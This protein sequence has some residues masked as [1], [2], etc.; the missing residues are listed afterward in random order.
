MLKNIMTLDQYKIGKKRIY[1]KPKKVDDWLTVKANDTASKLL[2]DVKLKLPKGYKI[3]AANH[4]RGYC[5][6]TKKII[7]IPSWVFD[8]KEIKRLA[9][10]EGWNSYWMSNINEYKIWYVA[11]ELSHSFAARDG[12]LHHHDKVFY[13]WF[14]LICPLKYQSFELTYLPS[15]VRYGITRK[16][17]Y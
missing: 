8:S 7:I 5:S 6:Y 3:Y 15:A 2:K 17:D 10:R 4:I 13:K 9:E 14:K 16:Y 1:L 11:H 12:K